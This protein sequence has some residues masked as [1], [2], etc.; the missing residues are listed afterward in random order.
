M[1]HWGTGTEATNSKCAGMDK[2]L[3]V[4]RVHVWRLGWTR[5][6]GAVAEIGSCGVGLEAGKRVISPPS[7]SRP[8]PQ[9]CGKFENCTRS[10]PWTLK[11]EYHQCFHLYTLKGLFHTLV[12]KPRQS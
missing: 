10:S 6:T 3:V 1:P 5:G 12:S 8:F 7:D 9:R 2:T 4:V 11:D